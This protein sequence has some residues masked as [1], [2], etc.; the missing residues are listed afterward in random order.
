MHNFG[1]DGYGDSDSTGVDIRLCV[2]LQLRDLNYYE[3][4]SVGV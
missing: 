2:C 4:Q 1:N 3:R